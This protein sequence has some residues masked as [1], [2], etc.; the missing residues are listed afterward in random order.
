MI[1]ERLR[2]DS[3][4]L[5]FLVVEGALAGFWDD[6][7]HGVGCKLELGVRAPG[8]ALL[9]GPEPAQSVQPTTDPCAQEA[10]QHRGQAMG[11]RPQQAAQTKG[12]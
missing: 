5:L 7:N 2:G 6:G 12:L 4:S 10:H 9:R 11:P 8:A 1:C 3:S